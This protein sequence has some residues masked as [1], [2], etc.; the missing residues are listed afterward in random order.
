MEVNRESLLHGGRGSGREI[1]SDK[2][3]CEK[4]R[5]QSVNERRQKENR[6]FF[7]VQLTFCLRLRLPTRPE[8]SLQYALPPTVETAAQVTR[9][10][11]DKVS[12]G[13]S[14]KQFAFAG[15]STQ[16]PYHRKSL[17]RMS[18]THPC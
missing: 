6:T 8:A 1:S 14:F 5:Q 2:I 17:Q 4:P 10:M 11:R 7:D 13:L 9:S 15:L 12:Q 3:V 18:A 16:P